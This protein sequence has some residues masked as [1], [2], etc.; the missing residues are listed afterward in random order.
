MSFRCFQLP[1]SS[2]SSSP[3]CSCSCCSYATAR[4]KR[5]LHHIF[6]LSTTA[7][8][9]TAASLQGAQSQLQ[10]L[11]R[12]VLLQTS[13]FSLALRHHHTA[14]HDLL[15]QHL[16]G[17]ALLVRMHMELSHFLL[18]GLQYTVSRI[19]RLFFGEQTLLSAMNVLFP[20]RK[21]VVFLYQNIRHSLQL[22]SQVFQ[23]L[24]LQLQLSLTVFDALSPPGGP[25]KLVRSIVLLLLQGRLLL[26]HVSPKSQ[27]TRFFLF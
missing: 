19:N 22:S 16:H 2:G 27:N 8:A 12:L 15:L 3:S 23:S 4:P 7:T 6:L 10:S 1:P 25:V 17:Q 9:A 20:H 24:S 18:L 26:S 11:R 14:L 13:H 21:L 5:G